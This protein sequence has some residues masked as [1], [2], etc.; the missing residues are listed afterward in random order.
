MKRIPL[1][2]SKMPDTQPTIAQWTQTMKG[3]KWRNSIISFFPVIWKLHIIISMFMYTHTNTYLEYTKWQHIALISIGERR[4][5]YTYKH[6]HPQDEGVEEGGMVTNSL[7]ESTKPTSCHLNTSQHINPSCHSTH[8]MKRCNMNIYR[9][10]STIIL[11]LFSTSPFL[12]QRSKCMQRGSENERICI[13]YQYPNSTGRNRTS[14]S[15]M[16]NYFWEREITLKCMY[17]HFSKGREERMVVG[18]C[19]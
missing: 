10:I 19:D 18:F 17:K 3:S 12:S 8:Q 9:R 6:T 5:L 7:A 1:N 14:L 15:F 11:K 13:K 16:H 4:N 2:L